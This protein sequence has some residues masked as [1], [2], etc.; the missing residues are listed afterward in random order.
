LGQGVYI[1]RWDY[2]EFFYVSCLKKKIRW[3][4]FCCF[5]TKNVSDG[6]ISRQI[7]EIYKVNSATFEL[8]GK[9]LTAVIVVVG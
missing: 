9:L 2:N 5:V 3:W 4:R 7:H 6:T 1:I 8:N